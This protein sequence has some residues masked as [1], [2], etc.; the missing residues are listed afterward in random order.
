MKSAAGALTVLE[1]AWV[2]YIQFAVSV[3]S[4]PNGGCPGPQFIPQYS[5]AVVGLAIVLTIVGLLGLWGARFAYQGGVLLSAVMVVILAY[6]VITESGYPYLAES[7]SQA[8]IGAVLAGV[9]AVSNFVAMRHRGRIS[10]QANP[11]NLPVFG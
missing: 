8:G 11:M 5:I 9:A 7:V 3:T 6:S 10:E 2:L 1:G 4:C